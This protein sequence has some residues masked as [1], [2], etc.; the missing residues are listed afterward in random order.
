MP[1]NPVTPRLWSP[2]GAFSLS[3]GGEHVFPQIFDS[4]YKRRRERE[5][6]ARAG[7]PCTHDRI[8][9]IYTSHSRFSPVRYL[10]EMLMPREPQSSPV[11]PAISWRGSRDLPSGYGDKWGFSTPSTP[12]QQGLFASNHALHLGDFLG[13]QKV[14]LLRFALDIISGSFQ[15]RS[16]LPATTT[17]A[18]HQS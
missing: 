7:C 3:P 4:H 8:Y 18:Q 1:L 14:T 5:Q 11:M 17:T 6:N 10:G 2:E 15:L 13:V 9:L 16:S 12:G